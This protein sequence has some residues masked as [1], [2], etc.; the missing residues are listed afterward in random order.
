MP[1]EAAMPGLVMSART[2]TAVAGVVGPAVLLLGMTVWPATGAGAES[3]TSDVADADEVEFD[4]RLYANPETGCI[5]LPPDDWNSADVIPV[6]P[7]STPSA[8][9]T[10]RDEVG[11]L[12]EDLQVPLLQGDAYVH[13]EPWPTCGEA[14]RTAPVGSRQRAGR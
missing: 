5:E 3:T 4:G 1:A 8:E 10:N 13:A 2:A 9:E 14:P 12:L 7:T 6:E 11:K